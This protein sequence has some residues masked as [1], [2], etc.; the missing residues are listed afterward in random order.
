MKRVLVAVASL[1]TLSASAGAAT[2]DVPADQ[3]TIQQAVDAASDGDRIRVAPGSWCGA[4]I[5]KELRLVGDRATIVGCAGIEVAGLRVGFF[6][7]GAAASGSRI[8]GFSFDGRGVSETNLAPLALGIFA[9]QAHSVVVR[10]NVIRGTVQG[11]TNTDGDDWRIVDNRLIGVTAFA[12][13]L[14]LCAGGVG[15]AIQR[16]DGG[17]AWGNRVKRNRVAD[18]RPAGADGLRSQR[19]LSDRA[20]GRAGAGKPPAGPR[21]RRTARQRHP[22]QR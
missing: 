12:C 11:I 19:G 8:K 15:I 21:Q 1:V 9:R 14:L 16:R 6:L 17:R 7:S 22:R 2:I 4:V 3:P 18:D 5:G 10:D 13:E 20:G